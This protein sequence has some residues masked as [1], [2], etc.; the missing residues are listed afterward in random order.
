MNSENRTQ[1]MMGLKDMIPELTYLKK[2]E[3]VGSK[4]GGIWTS[5]EDVCIYKGIPPFNYNLEY[6]ELLLS[7]NGDVN[8]KYKKMRV[9]EVYIHGI[10]RE[11]FSWLEERGWC[12]RW[13]DIGAL[14]FW[15]QE[16]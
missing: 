12:P 10:H 8:P 3:E 4:S 1:I 2:S 15:R 7:E 14:F 9:K 6:G 5:G 16:Y 11:I 13:L